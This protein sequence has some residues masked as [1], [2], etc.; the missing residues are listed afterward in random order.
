MTET[1]R[2]ITLARR[3]EGAPVP[4]DFKLETAPLPDPGPGE[5]LVAVE[6]LS[7][8]PYMRGR[9]DDAKSYA[10]PVALGGTMTGQG[11][12]RVVASR[13]EGFAAGDR[14]TGMTGWADHALLPGAELRKLDPAMPPTAAL[15]VLGMPGFTGWAGLRAYGRPKA[16]ETLVVGAATGPVGSM[17]GQLARMAGLRTVAVAGGPEKCAEAREVYG[18]DAAIDHRAHA[19]ASSLRRA[20]AEAAPDGVDIYWENVGGKLLEAV[21][22]LM[23]IHG[24]IPVCGMV[25]WYGG[26]EGAPILPV[27]WRAI[28]VKRLAVAGFIIFDHWGDYP[29]FLDEVGPKVAAGEIAWREDVAEGLENAPET[30]IRM[31]AGGNRGKQVVRI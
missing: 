9:M 20:L 6:H 17:V 2:R 14:V 30:F 23:N 10:E 22:P 24:R 15:G 13:A 3:P 8:D 11:V 16:G 7:L 28:L 25:A 18:F 21:L 29:A 31:L 26:A 19:D 27:A 12:G 1:L 4:E 5:V